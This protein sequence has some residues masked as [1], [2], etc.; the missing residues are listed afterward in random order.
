[1]MRVL[2]MPCPAQVLCDAVSDALLRHRARAL[3]AAAVPQHVT[4]AGSHWA[5]PGRSQR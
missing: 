4:P 5:L 2:H 1:V 3:R